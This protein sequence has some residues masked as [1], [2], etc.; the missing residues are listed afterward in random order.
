MN[1]VT[2]PIVMTETEAAFQRA[3]DENPA[4]SFTRE[5]LADYLDDIGD[6]RAA[7][8]RALGKLGVW[9]KDD[10]HDYHGRWW[11]LSPGKRQN[12]HCVTE[13]W[14]KAI[15]KLPGHMW[16]AP[17]RRE[18]EDAAALVFDLSFLPPGME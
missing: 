5:V 12:P 6:P 4:D 2:T 16:E 10:G 8:Y 9:P 7:G 14:N 15:C 11:F 13:A 17:T 1:T 3:L 18:V